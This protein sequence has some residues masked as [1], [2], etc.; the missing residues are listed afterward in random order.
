MA[1]EITIP[2]LSELSYFAIP[3]VMFLG[4]SGIIPIPEEVILLIIGYAAFS[5]VLDF[6]LAVL[7]SIASIIASDV[8][9]YYC[10]THGHGILK[11]FLKGKT[12]ARIRKSVERHGFWTVFVARFVPVMR[13]LTPWVAGTS[14]MRFREFLLANTL[15]TL[16]QTPLMVWIGFA[17]GPH[18]DKGIVVFEKIED[19]V[20][21][22]LS[23]LFI[24]VVIGYFY[25]HFTVWHRKR[26]GN[27]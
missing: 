9:H 12:I 2:Y 16:V 25:Y 1:L 10:A 14:G 26:N 11:R 8:I 20:P 19:A 7:F 13:I 27:R 3:I 22:I 24:L 18:V 17:L 6:W 4:S 5:G 21:L 23:L 15:G